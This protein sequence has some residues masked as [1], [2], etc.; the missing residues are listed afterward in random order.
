MP[1]SLGHLALMGRL[2]HVNVTED[3]EEAESEKGEHGCIRNCEHQLL[4]IQL[5]HSLLFLRLGN[6]AVQGLLVYSF[7]KL[8]FSTWLS[9]LLLR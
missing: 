3:A 2:L 7:G 4:Y 8:D 5:K 6:P 9:Y 1:S